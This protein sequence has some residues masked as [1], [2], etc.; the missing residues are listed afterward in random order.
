MMTAVI[1]T[2]TAVMLFADGVAIAL[3]LFNLVECISIYR[4]LRRQKRQHAARQLAQILSDEYY[5]Y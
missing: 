5:Y 3:S 2:S 4:Q 1:D